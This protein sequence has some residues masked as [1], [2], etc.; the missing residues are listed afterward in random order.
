MTAACAVCTV[1]KLS[2]AAMAMTTIK[3]QN[4]SM[5]DSQTAAVA[6]FA[7]GL[8]G[9]ARHPDQYPLAREAATGRRW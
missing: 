1:K 4:R 6:A 3:G 9:P 5:L 7:A 2:R 8:Y